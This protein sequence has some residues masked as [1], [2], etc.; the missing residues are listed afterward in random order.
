MSGRCAL[1]VVP[2]R[3]GRSARVTR[4]PPLR[5]PRASRRRGLRV[6]ARRCIHRR[7]TA[8]PGRWRRGHSRRSGRR[9]ESRNIQDL[10]NPPADFP[11]VYASGAAELLHREIRPPRI[12]Q[13]SIHVSCHSTGL[14]DRAFIH[15][16]ND[17]DQRDAG[18]HP[19]QFRERRPPGFCR[20]SE[21]LTYGRAGGVRRWRR[22]SVRSSG[23]RS[24]W[25]EERCA[26]YPR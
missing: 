20:R 2:P 5:M 6:F 26:Q 14:I 3:R 25:G 7:Q 17:L 23:E 21:S 15:D 12:K 16:M 1:R 18:K 24:R 10:A 9:Q 11:V 19:A 8:P 4:A 13:N 22:L